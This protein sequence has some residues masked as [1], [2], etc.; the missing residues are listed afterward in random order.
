MVVE[1]AM[2]SKNNEADDDFI[3]VV[4]LFFR[5]KRIGGCLLMDGCYF[6][7]LIIFNA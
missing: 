2:R 6:I 5:S 4:Y 3:C 1:A 7:V